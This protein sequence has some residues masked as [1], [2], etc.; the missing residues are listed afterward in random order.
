V[1]QGTAELRV[2]ATD[3]V[4]IAI[5][6][7]AT[8]AAL[9]VLIT[10]MGSGNEPAPAAVPGGANLADPLR[11][12][13]SAPST[14][15][16]TVGPQRSNLP[17]ATQPS[18]PTVLE[19]AVPASDPATTAKGLAS[20]RRSSSSGRRSGAPCITPAAPLGAKLKVENL[21]NGHEVECV[22]VA[23]DT[24]PN[25]WLIS[26]DATEFLQLGDPVQT[27]LPVRITW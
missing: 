10:S 19:I 4:R 18:Q 21:D 16:D 1:N 5:A 22:V 3:R 15:P 14:T 13:S 27:P 12:G 17:R 11:G 26:L 24:L 9:P 7:L 8:I 25:G 23:N 20:Y 6:T 2:E